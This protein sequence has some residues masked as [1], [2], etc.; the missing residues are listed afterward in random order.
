MENELLNSLVRI[1]AALDAQQVEYLIVGGTAV[2]LHGYFRYSTAPSG[3]AVTKPDLDFWYNPSYQNYFRLLDALESLG[4]NV[5]RFKAEQEP[6]P[7]KSYFRY[8]FEKFTLDLLPSLKASIK[9]ASAYKN[10]QVVRL[11]G[12]EVPFMGYEDLLLDK[13]TNARPKDLTDIQEL[14]NRHQQE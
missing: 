13:A 4:Q 12:I 10:K 2:A 11:T 3:A 8:E 5:D 1:C 14:K 9:F 6:N 7:Q